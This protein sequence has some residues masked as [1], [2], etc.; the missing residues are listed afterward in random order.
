ML[1]PR[2]LHRKAIVRFSPNPADYLPAVLTKFEGTELY[3]YSPLLRAYMATNVAV[4]GEGTGSVLDGNGAEVFETWK[5]LQEGDQVKKNN[6][7]L[8]R[9]PTPLVRE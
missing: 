2:A 8:P 4:T 6:Q 3:N 1:A 5:D 7:I 9:H